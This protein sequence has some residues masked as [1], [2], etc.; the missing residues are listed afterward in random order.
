MKR[1]VLASIFAIT[2]SHGL[3]AEGYSNDS[4]SVDPL[5]FIFFGLW[6]VFTGEESHNDPIE[7]RNIWFT[8]EANWETLRNQREM[9]VG[10]TLRK[11]R[12]ALMTRYR[13]FLNQERQSGLF[14]GLYGLLEWRRMFWSYDEDQ[15][16]TTYWSSFMETPGNSYHSIGITGGVEA[17]IRVR[18]DNFGM[19]MFAGA[20]VPL[21]VLFGNLPSQ[22]STL[23]FYLMNL[24]PRA[25]NVGIRMDFFAPTSWRTSSQ[26]AH[27]QS[28][29]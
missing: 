15:G 11:N 27:F 12:V 10:L 17:G 29:R 3:F 13:W 8:A 2:L 23:D 1:A 16:L 26:P 9:G 22:V 6:V 19:T 24:L 21:F 28:S 4:F 25:I 14:W 7:L 18:G 20:G 5:T